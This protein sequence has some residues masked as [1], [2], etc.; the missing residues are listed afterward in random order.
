MDEEALQKLQRQLEEMNTDNP[1]HT[2]KSIGLKN[3]N[4]RIKLLYGSEYGI[5]ID[6]K[7]LMGTKI[8]L[9]LPAKK[10]EIK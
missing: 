1:F 8:I 4:I 9:I 3:V 10:G 2:H 7:L 5:K 6:S